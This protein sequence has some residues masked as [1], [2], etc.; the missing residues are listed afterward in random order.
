MGCPPK[1]IYF[2]AQTT[3]SPGWR[4]APGGRTPSVRRPGARRA[5]ARRAENWWG[6]GNKK[7]TKKVQNNLRSP[8]VHQKSIGN[9]GFDGDWSWNQQKSLKFSSPQQRWLQEALATTPKPERAET[10][11]QHPRSQC[12]C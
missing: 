6:E 3:L 5:G 11:C 2:S 8:R 9:D 1:Q 12:Y 7:F 4:R 10:L